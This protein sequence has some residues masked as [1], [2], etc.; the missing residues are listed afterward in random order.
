MRTGAGRREQGAGESVETSAGRR[1]R[2]A[3]KYET[4]AGRGT[5][6]AR[7]DVEPGAVHRPGEPIER[8]AF[9]PPAPS[10]QPPE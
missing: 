5:R 7:K 8:G 9:L 2:G 10:P 4:G 3:G 6:W 1:V